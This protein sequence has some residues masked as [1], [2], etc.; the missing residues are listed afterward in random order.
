MSLP[1]HQRVV[2][3]I[4]RAL[5]SA[6]W[7]CHPVSI[8][9]VRCWWRNR[10]PRLGSSAMMGGHTVVYTPVINGTLFRIVHGYLYQWTNL[11]NTI[12]HICEMICIWYMQIPLILWMSMS[13]AIECECMFNFD[14]IVNCIF[15]LPVALP[16]T[17]TGPRLHVSPI[18]TAVEWG[19]PWVVSPV[20]W[21]PAPGSLT[22]TEMPQTQNLRHS[23]YDAILYLKD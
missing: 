14:E 1:V 6:Y 7:Y 19:W 20:H 4:V 15:C 22:L 10:D 13:Q 5:V 2:R 17:C 8:H 9:S 3:R 23:R 18:Q 11:H 16:S 12:I 21:S